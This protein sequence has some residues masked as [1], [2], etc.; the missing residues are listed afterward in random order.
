MTLLVCAENLFSGG[1]GGQFPDHVISAEEEPAG[2]EAW[3]V[4]DGRRSRT[5]PDY[6][7]ASTA[8][9][10]WWVQSVFDRMRAFNFVALDRGHNLAGIGVDLK[11]T[12]DATDFSGTYE[13]PLD[14]TLPAVATPYGHIDNGVGV[15]TEEGAWL[16]RFP[17]RTG[18]AVRFSVDA[19]GA[20][21]KPEIVGLWVGLAVELRSRWPFE[22]DGSEL[23]SVRM[24]SESGWIGRGRRTRRRRGEI[25]TKLQTHEQYDELIRYPIASLFADGVPMWIVPDLTQAEKAVLAIHSGDVFTMPETEG[26]LYRGDTP[27]AWAEYCPRSF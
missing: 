15:R 25:I 22:D 12:S 6:A 10:A 19:M 24:E 3:R 9:S 18:Q 5:P 7:T 20:G 23:V 26:A 21:L 16:Q 11:V 14:I 27:I 17:L 8:N 1:I 13:T 2:Y 4:G